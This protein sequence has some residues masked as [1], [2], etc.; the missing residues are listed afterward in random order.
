MDDFYLYEKIDETRTIFVSPLS[1]KLY[2]EA[3]A[4]TLGGADGYFICE[5]NESKPCAGFEILAKAA[6][7][8]AAIMIFEAIRSC[9]FAERESCA[10]SA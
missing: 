2:R 8:D 6:T 10:P 7:I 4:R 5:S 3:G 1:K 9:A